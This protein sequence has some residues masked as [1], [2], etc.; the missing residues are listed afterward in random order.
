MSFAQFFNSNFPSRPPYGIATPSNYILDS[1]G[2]RI[3]TLEVE[4]TLEESFQ[5][6]RSNTFKANQISIIENIQKRIFESVEKSDPYDICMLCESF[7]A[8]IQ[9]LDNANDIYQD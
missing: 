2:K 3:D 8:S 6:A 5:E 1:S 4:P 9:I 7:K